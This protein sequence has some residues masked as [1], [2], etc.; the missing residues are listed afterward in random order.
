M[1]I[2]FVKK[3]P[4]GLE[5]Y[6]TLDQEV[7]LNILISRLL[8]HPS[9]L[10][11]GQNFI[12]DTQYFQRW[13]MCTPRLAFDTM[14]AQNL[15]FPG[16]P[17]GLDYLSSLYCKY[18]WYWKED[19]KE[20]DGKG[21]L[22]DLLTYNCWDLVR[23]F[24]CATTLRSL[25]SRLGQEEQW[26]IKK[27]VNDLC[28]RMMNRGIRVDHARAAQ[29]G[30]ELAEALST[31]HH[32]LGYIV[33]QELVNPT[34]KTPWYKSAQQTNHLFYEVLGLRGVTHRKTGK[35]TGGK[36]A[37]NELP[38]KHPEFAGLF[39]RLRL[40]RSIDNTA[41]VVR[42]QVDSDGRMR[43]SFNPAG[44]E[45][46]RLSS[47]KNAFGGGMNLQNLTKGEEDE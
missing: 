20:W 31:I 38:K 5:S 21:S 33:P 26:E 45:T 13:N 25:I 22:E 12:Y 32:E 46:H 4:R 9:V 19:G 40:A 8:S 37:L 39:D 6:W 2:P 34:A 16:T 17:K 29:I 44:T 35:P 42:S 47:S 7:E 10:I 36:E 43:C 30:L 28:L 3:G 1:A 23:T 27:K 24:E 15:L 14:I 41:H 11:E 18:H